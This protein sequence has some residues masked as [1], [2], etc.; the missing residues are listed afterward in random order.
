MK[1]TV[2]VFLLLAMLFS[3][4][5]MTTACKKDAAQAPAATTAP[6]G[7]STEPSE[8]APQE[9]PEVNI[10]T[11]PA[12]VLPATAQEAVQFAVDAFSN[13]KKGNLKNRRKKH[14]PL[15]FSVI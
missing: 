5:A 8:T 10:D 13:G 7:Q 12:E 1:K 14:C 6:A 9:N 15:F 2:A 4:A 11:T 3:V